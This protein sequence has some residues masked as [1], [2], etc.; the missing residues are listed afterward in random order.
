MDEPLPRQNVANILD[1][2]DLGSS[3]ASRVEKEPMTFWLPA[4]YKKKYDDLQ[5]LSKRKFTKAVQEILMH[6]I[7]EAAVRLKTP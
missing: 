4:E 3:E 1:K 6:A 7:D 5:R 2:F